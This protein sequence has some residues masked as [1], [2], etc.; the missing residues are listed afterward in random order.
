MNPIK[1]VLLFLFLVAFSVT[2]S[3]LIINALGIA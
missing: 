2:V 3:M 1:L